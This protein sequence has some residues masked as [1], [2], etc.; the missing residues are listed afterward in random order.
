MENEAL[1]F[2]KIDERCKELKHWLA[3]NAP[4]CLM[5]E[6]HLQEGTYERA[7]WA[8]GYLAGL[9]DVQRLFSR[10]METQGN[11]DARKVA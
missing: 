10:G 11:Q 7:Y 8:H 4:Q 2:R 9:L 1:E 3:V 5:E 6:K